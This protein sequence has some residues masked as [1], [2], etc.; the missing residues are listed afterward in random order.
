MGKHAFMLQGTAKAVAA[1]ACWA[2]ASNGLIV[3]NKVIM[4]DDNFRYP[5]A[6]SSLGMF[7]SSVLAS[8]CCWIFDLR[9]HK[10]D[11]RFQLAHAYPVGLLMA[12]MFYTGNLCY[13]YLSLSCVHAAWTLALGCPPER[14]P[15]SPWQRYI[16]ML[17][18]AT[19][20]I[21]LAALVAARL[22][23]PSLALLGTVSLIVVG[24]AFTTAGERRFSWLGLGCMLMSQVADAGRLVLTQML[25]SSL[26]MHPL[27]ALSHLGPPCT[28]A[29]WSGVLFME[30]RDM[31]EQNALGHVWRR[32]LLYLTAALA[33]FVVNVAAF[34]VIKHTSSLTLKILGAVS[35]AV[36]VLGSAAFFDEQLTEIQLT[37]YS[38]SLIGFV[39]YNVVKARSCS[40]TASS[41][42]PIR[43]VGELQLPVIPWLV[44]PRNK[45]H[46]SSESLET[47][48]LM[49]HGGSEGS[50]SPMSP[51]REPR[52]SSWPQ[53]GDRDGIGRNQL[54]SGLRRLSTVADDDEDFKND[55]A[56]AALA[57][58]SRSP[59]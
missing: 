5:M 43:P 29:L 19:P 3:V 50:G 25:L 20:I 56:L 27:E 47:T 10:L 51:G 4:A 17:K 41:P 34:M 54:R 26:E 37:G 28:V 40:G 55:S 49:N 57:G 33:G 14:A 18:T 8:I 59:T 32:P 30:L 9:E 35:N 36:L 16:Q 12:V 48:A 13:L 38:I 7:A 6:L 58:R 31:R 21:T 45:E 11:F 23:H 24:M 22:E 44:K 2:I 1:C 42:L 53:D 39:L 15:H 52:N 46:L